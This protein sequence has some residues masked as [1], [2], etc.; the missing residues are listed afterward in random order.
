LLLYKVGKYI[1]MDVKNAFLH[2]DLNEELVEAST[3]P[4]S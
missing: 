4:R 3:D 2:E 1:K